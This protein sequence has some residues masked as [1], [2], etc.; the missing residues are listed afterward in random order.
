MARRRAIRSANFG[1]KVRNEAGG[2]EEGGLERCEGMDED[3]SYNI[4][5]T[6]SIDHD[7]DQGQGQ[8]Q[9]QILPFM[10]QDDDGTGF[11]SDSTGDLCALKLVSKEIFWKRVNL[12]KERG[13]S[14]IREVLSQALACDAYS[15]M[16]WE[17]VYGQP[18]AQP[19]SNPAIIHVP[20]PTSRSPVVSIFSVFETIEGFAVEMELM[21]QWDL[22]DKLSIDGVFPEDLAKH[23]VLQLID[24]VALCNSLGIAH[25]DVKLSNITFP[26]RTRYDMEEEAELARILGSRFGTGTGTATGQNHLL[27]PPTLFVKL[28]DFGMAGFIGT[29]NALKG[30]CGTPGYVAPEILK[31][32]AHESYGLNVDMFSIGVVA[33]TLLCGYEPFYGML[34]TPFRS[35]FSTG[36]ECISHPF[37]C[38]S[39]RR[40]RLG[41]S[42]GEQKH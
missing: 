23:V 41:V 39:F 34:G 25:R 31:A 19:S 9:D 14:L 6:F 22:F 13:D 12:G 33:Y 38:T 27:S 7:H 18:H 28:A 3:E 1:I 15:A 29:D 37:L 10:E 21:E 36:L 26:R 40:R 5:M 35:I 24:A 17:W 8:D 30:R 4:G 2:E 16:V 11:G 42:P 32:N 20:T